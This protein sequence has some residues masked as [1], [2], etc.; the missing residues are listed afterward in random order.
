VLTKSRRS[1]RLRVLLFWSRKDVRVPLVIHGATKAT[2]E[3]KSEVVPMNF[4]ILECLNLFQ[5]PSSLRNV[6]ARK[7]N[8][9]LTVPS[10]RTLP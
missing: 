8:E 2:E 1:C 6:Y 4:K 10:D 5:I 3:P 9:N 7:L